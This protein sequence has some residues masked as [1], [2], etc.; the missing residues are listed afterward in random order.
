MANA[1]AIWIFIS[2]MLLICFYFLFFIC[3]ADVSFSLAPCID[4]I[5][6]TMVETFV[7]KFRSSSLTD[8]DWKLVS[9]LPQLPSSDCCSV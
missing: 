1:T 2:I 4:V 5:L 7:T 6:S 9:L 8:L 3:I